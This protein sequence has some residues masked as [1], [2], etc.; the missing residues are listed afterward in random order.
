ML[1]QMTFNP[2]TISGQGTIFRG[3][4]S[5]ATDTYPPKEGTQSLGGRRIFL[6][7]CHPAR[8][9]DL[10]I[11]KPNKK[12]TTCSTHVRSNESVDPPSFEDD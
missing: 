9:V 3:L 10:V 1:V 6:K 8:G 5:G 12:E 2:E 7:P 11:R 4:E